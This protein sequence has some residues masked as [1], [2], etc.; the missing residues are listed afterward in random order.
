MSPESDRRQQAKPL[1]HHEILSLI[2]PF[3]RRG[4]HADLAA[5]DRAGRRLVFKPVEH[6]AAD[7]RPALREV[8]AL[9]LPETGQSRLIRTVTDPSGLVSTLTAQ[10]PD[11]GA[12]LE[13]VDGVSVERQFKVYGDVTVARSYRIAAVKGDSEQAASAP[14]PRITEAQ[15][16]VD[17][18]N[19]S[20]NALQ[21]PNVLVEVKL[22]AD[23]GEEL[24]I[25]EDLLSVLGWSWRPLRHFVSY[26][27]GTIRVTPK[28][29]ER[30][31]DIEHKLGRSIRHLASTLA[32]AP[33]AFHLRHRQ[34]RWRAA[35]QRSIPLTVGLLILA[36]TPAIGWLHME[37]GSLLRMFIFH[38]PP[39]M[40]VGFFM[41][42]ELPRLEI[43]PLP[44]QLHPASWIVPATRRRRSAQPV[45]A[46]ES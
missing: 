8:L 10:G 28:E 29:P 44:R 11:A 40:M 42:R 7:G 31:A 23:P 30:T 17:G 12:L 45:N 5:S 15:A 25:P 39:I 21:G 20:L 37:D 41:F 34:A 13:W 26:W 46:T 19:F 24:R 4:R 35:F 1:T 6:P 2:A 22:T 9:E 36:A 27:R 38:A 33:S 16:R 14:R 3:T 18:V 43:P 32:E